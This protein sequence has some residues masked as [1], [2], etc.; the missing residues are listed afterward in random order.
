MVE[1]ELLFPVKKINQ[2]R[3]PARAFEKVLFIDQDHRQAPAFG[4]QSIV[5]SGRGFFFNEQFF[6]GNSPFFCG[7]DWWESGGF[8]SLIDL[9]TRRTGGA[10]LD[11]GLHEQTMPSCP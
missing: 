8:H 1:E 9:Q 5:S 3:S 6:P 7:H 10:V 4:R 2:A 11:N